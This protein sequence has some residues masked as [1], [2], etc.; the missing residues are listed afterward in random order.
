MKHNYPLTS[1]GIICGLFGKTRQGWYAHKWQAAQTT[2]EHA[3]VLSLVKDIRELQPGAGTP[4]LY[5]MLRDTLPAHHI[6]MGRAALNDLLSAH[7]MLI[8][9]KRRKPKTTD[10][11][12]LYRRYDNLI[13]GVEIDRPCQVWVS[14]ITY[15]TVGDSFAYLSLITDVYSRKI[16]GYTLC[17]TLASTG[18]LQ[19]L[20]MALKTTDRSAGPL[21]HHSD[22]GVQYCCS[23]YTGLLQKH[24][25]SISM[26]RKGDP[27]ENPIAERVNGLLKTHFGIGV[28]FSSMAQA[29]AAID[30]AITTYNTVR[31][32]S[33][34]E[35]LTPEKAHQQRGLLTRRWKNY[36]KTSKQPPSE[37]EGFSSG[38]G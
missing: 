22:R 23:E 1:L 5:K 35:D 34:C 17:E 20:G 6:K 9:K 16:I 36:R 32:H 30:V 2:L 26:S 7:G 31:P 28:V 3:I 15:I 8:R 33:S 27:Y 10:S 11:A 24:G 29:K 4:T 13:K 38:M 14:D 37:A 25:I 18:P 19:A 21:V 12:H